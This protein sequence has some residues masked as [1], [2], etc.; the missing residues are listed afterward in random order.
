VALGE[1]ESKTKPIEGRFRK[2]I[3]E[4]RAAYDV[5]LIDC[6]PA[7]SIFTKTA[8][9]NSDHVLI[10]VAPERY[11]VRGV[12][13]MLT[14]VDAQRLGNSGPEP[15]I[16]FNR[17]PRTGSASQE[18]TIRANARYTKKCLMRTLKEYSAFAEP[19]EGQG[20]VW[21]SGKP[22]SRQARSNLFSV[23]QE[24]VHKLQI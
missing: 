10:P 12:G 1:P 9:Q 17:M 6:H 16:L 11:S 8:L 4:A 19:M 15:H 14:F 13:L 22:W 7:G 23:T 24:I 5:V 20:F 3:N 18:Q 2:F 21:F